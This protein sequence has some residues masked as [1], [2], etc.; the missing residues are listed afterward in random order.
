M[1][2][3]PASMNCGEEDHR[4]ASSP[5]SFSALMQTGYL[6]FVSLVCAKRVDLSQEITQYRSQEMVLSRHETV[7]QLSFPQMNTLACMFVPTIHVASMEPLLETVMY[8][9]VNVIYLP[10]WQKTIL[11]QMVFLI[12]LLPEKQGL[13]E[14]TVL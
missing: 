2:S 14:L 1:E 3:S 5:S 7:P 12:L 13:L 11:A 8:F 9:Y 4:V 10:H 6:T